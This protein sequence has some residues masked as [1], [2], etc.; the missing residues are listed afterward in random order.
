DGRQVGRAEDHGG[1]DVRK[2]GSRDRGINPWLPKRSLRLLWECGFWTAPGSSLTDRSYARTLTAVPPGLPGRVPGPSTATPAFPSRCRTPPSTR[3][4]GLTPVRAALPVQR[5][6][7]CPCRTAPQLRAPLAAALG[8]RA[9]RP[10]GPDRPR[11]EVVGPSPPCQDQS[12]R[13]SFP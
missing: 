3:A 7:R 1:R 4:T 10:R 8:W 11:S 6:R 9:I 5:R 13:L 2:R 12:G